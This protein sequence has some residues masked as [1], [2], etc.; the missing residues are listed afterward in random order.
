MLDSDLRNALIDDIKDNVDFTYQTLDPQVK[1]YRYGEGFSRINPS[2]LIGFLP[3]NRKRFQ[4]ISDV[5]GYAKGDY[6]RYGFAR[7]E[8]CT[9]HSYCQEKHETADKSTTINGRMLCEFIAEKCLERVLKE[10]ENIL[11]DYNSSFDRLDTIPIVRDLSLYDEVSE[12][13]IYN[14]DIDIYLRIPYTWDKV[15]DGYDEEGDLA[16]ILSVEELNELNNN[17]TKQIII[18]YEE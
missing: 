12:T 13:Q 1:V 2:I 16:N 17:K 9:I 14:Y 6:Y 4:S 18:R 11:S 3:S 8:L 15:P 5:I 7:V 10:W